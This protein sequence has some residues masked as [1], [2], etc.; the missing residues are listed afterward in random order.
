MDVLIEGMDGKI[1]RYHEVKTTRV[2]RDGSRLVLT[3]LMNA[4]VVT[5]PIRNLALWEI[6]SVADNGVV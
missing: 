6:M 5:F 4:N 1:H 3:F 2:T